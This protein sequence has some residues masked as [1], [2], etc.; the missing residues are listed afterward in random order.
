MV[1]ELWTPCQQ[2]I[3]KEQKALQ[4]IAELR[5]RVG[6]ES[7]VR[8]ASGPF[9]ETLFNQIRQAAADVLVIGR[10]LHDATSRL[11]D[12]SYSLVRDSPGPVVSV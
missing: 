12:L 4:R 8:V 2:F 6:S 10:S 3:A 7:S 1:E 5:R 9:R 11:P